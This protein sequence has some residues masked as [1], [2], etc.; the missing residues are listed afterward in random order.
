MAL[1]V[2]SLRPFRQRRNGLLN[3]CGQRWLSSYVYLQ[4]LPAAVNRDPLQLGYLLERF[5]A[6]PDGVADLA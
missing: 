5:R 6:H 1:G 3:H 4:C 2:S